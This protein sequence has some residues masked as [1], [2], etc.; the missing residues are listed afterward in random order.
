MTKEYVD[1]SSLQ[2]VGYN[3]EYQ[4]LEVEFRNGAVYQYYNCPK[5]MYDELMNSPSKGQ[6]F[7]SQIRDRFPFSRV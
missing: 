6:F 2:S 4:T 7:H 3:E 5:L 1:S